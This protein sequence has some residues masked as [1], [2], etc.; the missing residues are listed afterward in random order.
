MIEHLKDIKIILKSKLHKNLKELRIGLMFYSKAKDLDTENIKLRAKIE[1][2]TDLI[3]IKQ[4]Y[5]K[6][7][8]SKCIHFGSRLE[9]RWDDYR[10]HNYCK[11]KNEDIN[12]TITTAKECNLFKEK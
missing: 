4:P 7:D 3:M 8:C 2:L 9:S 12:G 6:K 1:L 10:L 11:E 5:Q